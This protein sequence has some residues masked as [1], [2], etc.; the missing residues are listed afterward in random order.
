MSVRAEH[1]QDWIGAEVVD[2]SGESLG[3]VAEVFYR[4]NDPLVIEIRSGLVGRKHHLAVLR[5]ATVSKDHLRLASDVL[6]QTDGGLG[7]TEL[8]RLAGEDDRLQGRSAAG[9][10]S[11]Q[12][13]EDRLHA[14]VQAGADADELDRQASLRQQEA[15]QAAAAA[16]EAA[17]RAEHAEAQHARAREEAEK[18]RR[19]ADELGR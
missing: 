9:L 10:E 8:Q 16:D 15:R 7:D 18:A 17:N 1:L 6:V 11:T 12:A 5:G 4:G 2:S 13:R 3:K 14:A 19:Q